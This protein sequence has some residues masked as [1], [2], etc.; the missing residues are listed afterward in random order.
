MHRFENAALEFHDS[1]VREVQKAGADLLLTFSAAYVHRSNGRPGVDAGAGYLA[2]LLITF[3][4]AEWSGDLGS[5]QGKL[6]DGELCV[7][8]ERLSLVPLPY[9]A[10]GSVS[11]ELQFA[12]GV[13]LSI[14]ASSVT[15]L[16]TGGERFVESYA[17]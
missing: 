14:R 13:A 16:P 3:R 11:A 9:V 7:G 12:N 4:D 5:C 10:S 8:S 6:S 17:C 2:E 1:E 15:C